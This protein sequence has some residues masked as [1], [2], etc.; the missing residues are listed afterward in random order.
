[1][2]LDSHTV[3]LIDDHRVFTN[4]LK[5]LLSQ[6]LPADNI[7]EA[8]TAA[9]A[10]T[11]VQRRHIDL[12][13]I[14][15]SLPDKN[16]LELFKELIRIKPELKSLF[17]SMANEP[18]YIIQAAKSGASGY[19]LKTV[20]GH[21]LLRAVE[22]I[23][24]GKKYFCTEAA[25]ILAEFMDN[26]NN[27]QRYKLTHREMEI[28][29]YIADGLSHPAIAECLHISPRTVESHQRNIF[30]KLGLKN[31]AELIRFVVQNNW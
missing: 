12:A 5:S 17:L 25:A 9:Q 31:T 15:I 11:I 18:F 16:G 22:M 3:L 10:F 20:Q 13:V 8:N 7:F 19:M 30:S 28:A 21:E 4:A 24:H 26:E 29:H 23:M 1:M 6:I 27:H 14:D 2:A